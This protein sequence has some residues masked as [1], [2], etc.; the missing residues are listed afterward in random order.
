MVNADAPLDSSPWTYGQTNGPTDGQ[1]LLYSCVSAT[2]KQSDSN[3]RHYNCR[4][5]KKLY[6]FSDSKT[7]ALSIGSVEFLH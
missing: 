2:K 6:L 4:F 5:L 3:A 1:S 7:S